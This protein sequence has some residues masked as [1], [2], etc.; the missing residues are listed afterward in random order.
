M[1]ASSSFCLT[2]DRRLVKYLVCSFIAALLFPERLELMNVR[3]AVV[4]VVCLLASLSAAI[5]QPRV[6]PR[7][8]YQRV[9]AIVP[10]VGSGTE[11]DPRRPEYAPLP[12][13]ATTA[14]TSATAA[15][16]APAPATPAT[17][18]AGSTGILG[19]A[20]VESDDGNFAIVEF[21]SRSQSIFQNILADTTIQAFLMGRDTRQA[22]EAAFQKL[23]PSFSIANFLVRLP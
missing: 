22:A 21:V 20:M 16:S 1:R 3:R 6:D 8:M 2:H 9:I 11:A 15:P 18:L 13:A 4:P 12:P 17:P 14:T 23:K 5:A 19:Y 7:N 10:M